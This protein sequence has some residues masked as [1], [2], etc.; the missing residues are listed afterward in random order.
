V[1]TETV[2]GDVATADCLR[3]C[4]AAGS[5]GRHVGANAALPL[6]E[7]DLLTSVSFPPQS[8]L[9]DKIGVLLQI[10]L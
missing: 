8:F 1:F 9:L 5:F 7:Q 3:R 4:G 6:C 2:S 10:G